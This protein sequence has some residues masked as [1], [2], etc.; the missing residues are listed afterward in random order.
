MVWTTPGEDLVHCTAGVFPRQVESYRQGRI[1]K[2]L[3]AKQ[4]VPTIK[5]MPHCRW[6][7]L[8]ALFAALTLPLEAAA[9]LAMS[10][11]GQG[12]GAVMAAVDEAM[13]TM[14]EDCPMHQQQAPAPAQT[15][16]C[17]HCGICHLAASGFA[18]SSDASLAVVPAVETYGANVEAASLSHIPEPPLLPPRRSA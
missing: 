6:R 17:G 7:F 9:G 5:T 3:Q 8:L 16:D 12:A 14:P 11:D 1:F 2:R 4:E 10:I 18:I 15:G 13:A